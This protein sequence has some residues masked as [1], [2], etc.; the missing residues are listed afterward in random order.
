[1]EQG[2]Q[3]PAA[4]TGG[5]AGAGTSG[6]TTGLGATA[7]EGATKGAARCRQCA[8]LLSHCTGDTAVFA[9]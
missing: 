6:G 1:M 5:G 9:F 4:A 2:G 8:A 7:E 3:T